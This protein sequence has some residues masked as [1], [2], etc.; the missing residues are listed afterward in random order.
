MV[1]KNIRINVLTEKISSLVP[2]WEVDEL[3]NINEE[4][5]NDKI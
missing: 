1:R 2:A 5:K 4:I 3:K